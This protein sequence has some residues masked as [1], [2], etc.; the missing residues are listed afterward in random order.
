MSNSEDI[1]MS[2]LSSHSRERKAS[3]SKSSALLKIITKIHV[4]SIKSGEQV[5]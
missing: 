2:Y 4:M 3:Y 1:D 5:Q